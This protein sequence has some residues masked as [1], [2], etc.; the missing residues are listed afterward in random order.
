MFLHKTCHTYHIVCSTV[1]T[2]NSVQDLPG[3]MVQGAEFLAMYVRSAREFFLGLDP[4]NIGGVPC[5]TAH[6]MRH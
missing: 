4:L 2:I 6:G 3:F 1:Q 5:H